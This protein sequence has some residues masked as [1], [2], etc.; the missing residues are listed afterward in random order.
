MESRAIPSITYSQ[1]PPLQIIM[2]ELSRNRWG[3]AVVGRIALGALILLLWA[4]W[5]AQRAGHVSASVRPRRCET[6]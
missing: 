4:P 2:R 3:I 6:P 1:R 5:M